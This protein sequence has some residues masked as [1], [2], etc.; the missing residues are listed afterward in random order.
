M[1]YRRLD[2]CKR[3][4]CWDNGSKNQTGSFLRIFQIEPPAIYAT[5]RCVKTTL[6][7]NYLREQIFI[8]S[9]SQ[10]VF[11]AISS[12][13]I[14]SAMVLECVEKLN[15]IVTRN[16]VHQ[17]GSMGTKLYRKMNWPTIQLKKSRQPRLYNRRLSSHWV[18]T[19]LGKS[20]GKKKRQVGIVTGCKSLD[21]ARKFYFLQNTT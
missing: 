5:S 9:N 10:P 16:R 15:R 8:S 12:S 11:Q 14:Q 13:E 17:R 20:S 1:M 19:T 3:N 4:L 6:G 2:N 21:F 7:I 18:Y